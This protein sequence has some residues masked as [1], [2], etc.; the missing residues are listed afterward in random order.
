MTDAA[1]RAIDVVEPYRTPNVTPGIGQGVALFDLHAI[2]IQDKHRLL[3]PV[4][5]AASGHTIT[6]K[7][8]A[9]FANVLRAAF[10][11]ENANVTV[12]L[13]LPSAPL[14][15]GS[16]LCT[17]PIGEVDDHMKFTFRIAFGEPKWVRGKEIVSTLKNMH[18]LVRKTIIDFDSEG[19]L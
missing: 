17:L 4:W 12:P 6:K 19:L 7:R 5:V 9:E 14:E 3:I 11:S 8:R 2:N 16:K 13:E 10:G 15:D 1:I 18:R